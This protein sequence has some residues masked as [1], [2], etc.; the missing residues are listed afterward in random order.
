MAAKSILLA[1][2][3]AGAQSAKLSFGPEG[4][5]SEDQDGVL[6]YLRLDE[7]NLTALQERSRTNS[8][9]L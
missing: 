8:K 7:Q 1:A 9:K 6:S 4:V 2:T 3:L 5:N